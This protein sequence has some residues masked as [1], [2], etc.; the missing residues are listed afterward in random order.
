MFFTK[1]D[2]NSTV[3]QIKTEYRE[4]VMI[5]HPDSGNEEA[6]QENFSKLNEEYKALIEVANLPKDCQK[7]EGTGMITKRKGLDIFKIMCEHCGGEG[8]V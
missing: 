1:T 4:L 7:C 5:Y 6:T 2:E 8:Y 3:G